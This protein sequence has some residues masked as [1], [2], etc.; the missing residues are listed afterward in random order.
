M[1][2]F[3]KFPVF[4]NMSRQIEAHVFF[5]STGSR[6]AGGAIRPGG[7]GEQGAGDHGCVRLEAGRRAAAVASGGPRL[8]HT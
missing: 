6:R 5:P 2:S 3:L 4:S 8:N 1:K 7:M